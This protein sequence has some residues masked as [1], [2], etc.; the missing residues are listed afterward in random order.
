MR[1]CV[2]VPAYALGQICACFG[3][4]WGLEG[5]LRCIFP[6]TFVWEKFTVAV[7]HPSQI[8]QSF[9]R[10]SSPHVPA[11]CRS[12]GITDRLCCAWCLLASV[13]WNSDPWTSVANTLPAPLVLSDLLSFL[14]FDR[15]FFA[16]ILSLLCL[17]V[18]LWSPFPHPASQFS[19]LPLPCF[20]LSSFLFKKSFSCQ[21]RMASHSQSSC[22][23]LPNCLNYHV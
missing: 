1:T 2:C 14:L 15:I 21:L 20:L 12:A 7:H 10:V 9:Q 19:T 18:W 11:H 17:S 6:S 8:A 5:N 23:S 22:L 13:N 16:H 4:Y 3:E